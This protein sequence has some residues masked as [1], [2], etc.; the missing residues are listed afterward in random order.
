MALYQVNQ[1]GFGVHD[2]SDQGVREY[3]KRQHVGYWGYRLALSH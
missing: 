3:L 1:E 2:T